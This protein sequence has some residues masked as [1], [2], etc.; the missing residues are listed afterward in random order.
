[1]SEKEPILLVEKVNTDQ[2]ICSRVASVG[3]GKK[4][5]SV[6]QGYRL[7]NKECL[8]GM[9]IEQDIT[10]CVTSGVYLITKVL[11]FT[12]Q[13]K[14]GSGILAFTIPYSIINYCGWSSDPPSELSWSY[15]L[16]NS[17]IV[18][19]PSRIVYILIIIYYLQTKL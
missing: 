19:I 10:C 1:M 11:A 18:I 12:I 9:S 4:T 8:K 3:S 16:W 2:N 15:N 13:A 7:K 17:I 5:S 14:I 6:L